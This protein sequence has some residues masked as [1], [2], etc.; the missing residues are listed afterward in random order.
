MSKY[1]KKDE[2]RICSSKNLE[3]ILDLGEQPPSN[4]FI[5]K[6]NLEK[7]ENKFPL[8]LYLCKECYLLQ[9]LDIVNKEILFEKYLYLTSASK[10]IVKHFEKCIRGHPPK[11]ILSIQKVTVEPVKKPN[12][13]SQTPTASTAKDI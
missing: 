9:L 10:P 4:A 6:E 5:K 13:Y 2:C 7:Y 8:R 3:L 11:G 12:Y 1:H